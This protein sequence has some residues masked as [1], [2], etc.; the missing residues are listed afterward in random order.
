MD[1]KYVG[2]GLKHTIILLDSGVMFSC[3]NNEHGQLGQDE[4][5]TRYIRSFIFC[6]VLLRR[7]CRGK[8]IK[9]QSILCFC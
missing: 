4:T 9:R 2:C 1:V 7:K 5:S 3:G 8:S 6:V